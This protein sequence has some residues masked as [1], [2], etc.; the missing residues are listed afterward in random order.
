MTAAVARPAWLNRRSALDL[1]LILLAAAMT[2]LLFV[3]L[4]HLGLPFGLRVVA[5]GE[6]Y[7]WLLILQSPNAVARAQT[8]WSFN[9]RNP[10]SPWWYIAARRLYADGAN[11]PYLT[12]LLMGPLLGVSLYAAVRA[13]AMGR[14]RGLALGAAMLGAAWIIHTTP[15]EIAWNFIGALSL[16][17]LCVAAYAAWIAGGRARVGWYGLSLALWYGAF[18]T[19]GF[20]VG[21]VVGIGLLALL[22]PPA[23]SATP[24]RRIGSA[25]AETLPYAL[26]FGTFV[27]AW[28]TTQNP[29]L[30]AYY[31]L[32]PSLL[33]RNLPASLLA[34]LSP[35]RYGGYLAEARA[36]LGG[37]AL[38]LGVVFGL[39]AALLHFW[40]LRRTAPATRRD[41]ALVLA[42]AGGIVLPTLLIESM[43]GTW[44]VGTR[45]PMVDQGWLPLLWMGAAALLLALLPLPDGWR[46]AGLSAAT[47]AVA[48]WLLVAC[49]GYNHVQ[50]RASAAELA[51]RREMTALGRRVPAGT[52]FNFVV[53][54]E[55]GVRLVTPDVMS[56]RVA[57]VWW[58][59]RDFGLRLLQRNR[60]PEPDAGPWARVIL[61]EDRGEYLRIGDGVAPYPAVRILRFD[62]QRIT[63]PSVV[64]EDDVRGYPVEWRRTAPLRQD[65]TIP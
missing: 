29:V 1:G 35:A 62:G 50:T 43:S 45:W 9:D 2:P 38:A 58:P 65:P 60:P 57:P 32:D 24:S 49:L 6:D 25:V 31:G 41:A 61:H 39:G 55:E 11:G 36:V 47:G 23:G 59:G 44:T 20:Q 7:N 4:R 10:L 37:R 63:V 53:L 54:A 27:L 22:H 15:D 5:M 3:A 17:L 46:R 13:V 64:T 52:P 8:F 26:I 51:L 28:K 34:G 19:Y 16:S 12:R 18:A 30:A 56:Y 33:L 21:A 14:A 48:A 40:V 42:V